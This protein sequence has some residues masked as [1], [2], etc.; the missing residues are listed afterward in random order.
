MLLVPLVASSSE[1]TFNKEKLK[2]AS[3]W[4]YQLQDISVS[5]IRNQI[6]DLVVIEPVQYSEQANYFTKRQV[7]LMKNR[8][9]PERNKL[10]IAY[11][12]IGE[13]EDYRHYWKKE[14]NQHPPSWLGRENPDWKGNYKV[15]YWNKEWQTIMLKE[16]DE[17][18]KAGFDGV[19]LDI[20]DAFEYWSEKQTYRKETQQ[21]NDPKGD[22]SLAADLM[23]HWISKIANHSRLNS[24]RAN[25]D[26]IVLPQ[27]GEGLI[28]TA[29]KDNIHLY[30]N[31]IDGIG[32]E[33]LFH[34]G[35]DPEDNPRNLNRERIEI[36]KQFKEKGKPLFVIDYLTNKRLIKSFC[37]QSRKFAFIPFVSNRELNS[38]PEEK[39]QFWCDQ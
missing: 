18:L 20:I 17:I 31:S 25:S 37:E 11:L 39:V 3:S 2:R 23:V 36:L 22:V 26:F 27:N 19:Y 14:W 9:D 16:L 10:L 12:S 28:Q 13:A 29:S 21:K 4:G 32:V 15:R 30:W 7:S 38:I 8:K 6:F 5:E 24:T 1:K 35:D 34:P 33:D